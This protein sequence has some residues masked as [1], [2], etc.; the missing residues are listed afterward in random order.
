MKIKIIN[1]RL[2]FPHLFEAKAFDSGGTPKFSATMLLDKKKHKDV[3]AQIEEACDQLVDE[4]WRGKRPKKLRL[5]LREGSEKDDMDGYGDDVRFISASSNRRPP[6]VS[7]TLEPL[8]KEDGKPYAG[9]YVNASI[10]L[11]VQDNQYGQAVNAE[12]LA[13]QFAKD[14]EPFGAAPVDASAEFEAIDG[15]ETPRSRS[16]SRDD[17]PRNGSPSRRQSDDVM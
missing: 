12:L 13:V 8:T 3:I 17:K 16:T 14:G 7:Q 5:P 4:T 1:A 15:D 11:W 2:S 9:C 6:V 10:R